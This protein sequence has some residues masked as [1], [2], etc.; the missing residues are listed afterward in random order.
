MRRDNH[1][2][3]LIPD[4]RC[5]FLSWRRYSLYFFE[6]AS[7]KKSRLIANAYRHSLAHPFCTVY[8]KRRI[9]RRGGDRACYLACTVTATTFV[10]RAALG[11]QGLKDKCITITMG[12][13]FEPCGLAHDWGEL[14]DMIRSCLHTIATVFRL[15]KWD[16]KE[17]RR[18]MYS[19][20]FV[21]S[22]VCFIRV[23][24][25]LVYSCF[26]LV[27]FVTL[28]AYQP[29]ASRCCVLDAGISSIIKLL[30][31]IKFQVYRKP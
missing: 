19:A 26:A 11:L 31:H 29:R 16:S 27:L 15:L 22:F 1:P 9:E 21:C 12:E 10:R 24:N 13:T 6:H 4:A 5:R 23:M 28:R 20:W 17:K 3:S 7:I 2:P 18:A 30:A 14:R 8:S 25:V